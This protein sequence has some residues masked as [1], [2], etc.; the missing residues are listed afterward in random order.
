MFYDDTF[1][2][3]YWFN[4]E[5]ISIVNIN[6]QDWIKLHERRGFIVSTSYVS[7]DDNKE[8]KVYSFDIYDNRAIEWLRTYYSNIYRAFKQI[9]YAIEDDEDVKL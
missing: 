4:D 7:T 6:S 5:Y 9:K 3:N 2:P 8:I 1:C